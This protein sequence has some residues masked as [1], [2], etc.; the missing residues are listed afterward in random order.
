MLILTAG[1]Y[2]Y[3]DLAYTCDGE[4]PTDAERV[5]MAEHEQKL[6]QAGWEPYWIDDTGKGILIVFRRPAAALRAEMGWAPKP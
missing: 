3:T 4:T 5:E 1:A 6:T 2:H